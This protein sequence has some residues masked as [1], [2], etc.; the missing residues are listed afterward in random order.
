MAEIKIARYR[1][2]FTAINYK[3]STPVNKGR[4]IAQWLW[5]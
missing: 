4:G 2:T 1:K 3:T 5:T